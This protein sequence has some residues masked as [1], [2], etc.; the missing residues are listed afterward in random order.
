[1]IH[2]H[3]DQARNIRSAVD[4][5]NLKQNIGKY[6]PLLRDIRSNGFCVS[7]LKYVIHNCLKYTIFVHNI[8]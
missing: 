7:D 2:V 8:A 5:I 4:V 6:K 1:M 3:A